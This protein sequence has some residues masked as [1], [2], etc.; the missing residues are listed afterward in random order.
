MVPLV[1]PSHRT[2]TITKSYSYTNPTLTQIPTSPYEPPSHP[3]GN[4]T[5]PPTTPHSPDSLSKALPNQPPFSS[6]SGPFRS[7]PRI[8][9][10]G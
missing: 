7:D 5:P 3:A 6:L 9:Q 4:N 1:P 2:A 8:R 10:E